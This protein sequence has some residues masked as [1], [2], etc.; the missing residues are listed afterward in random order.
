LFPVA[1]FLKCQTEVLFS[2]VFNTLTFYKAVPQHV[3]CV[4]WLPLQTV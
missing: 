4:A 2:I 1:N 3:W